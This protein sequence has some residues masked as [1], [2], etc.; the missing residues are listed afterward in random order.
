MNLNETTLFTRLREAAGGDWTKFI[1]HRFVKALGNG[2]LAESCFRY[3]LIQDYLFLFHFSRAYA[4]AAYKAE[5]LEDLRHSATAINNIIDVELSLHVEYC[6]G[7]GIGVEDLST[8]PEDIATTAYTRFVLDCGHRGDLLD[9]ATALAPCVTGYA[10][11]GRALAV[12]SATIRDDN[13]YVSWIDMYASD[14]YQKVSG[15][16]VTQ[17]Q[18]LANRRGGEMRFSALSQV[19]NQ[20]TRLETGFWEMGWNHQKL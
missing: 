14:E 8:E 18:E 19:F 9:L 7:W 12:D 11:I 20:A 1:N 5:T 13:P 16:S 15:D 6:L 10:E 2:T 3:Y 17:L 4:L